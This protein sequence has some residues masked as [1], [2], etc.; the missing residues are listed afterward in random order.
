M[1]RKDATHRVLGRR[2]HAARIALRDHA[3]IEHDADLVGHHHGLVLVVRHVQR[4]EVLGGED[5]SELARQVA[6]E[7]R[8]HV[9][10]R[11]IEEEQPG[12]QDEGPGERD[13]LRL[14]TGE[15]A[16]GAV[17]PARE[18]DA[19]QRLGHAVRPL[20]L[21]MPRTRRP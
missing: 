1:P 3:P 15:Q 5:L 20:F 14:T 2:E 18:P 10:Q 11:L 9:G 12:A 7:Q 8:V 21:R 13:A 6:L 16:G 19:G 17:L 4:G